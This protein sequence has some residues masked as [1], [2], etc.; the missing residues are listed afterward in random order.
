MGSSEAGFLSGHRRTLGN[1]LQPL[2]LYSSRRT[3]WRGSMK[4]GLHF[5]MPSIGS[6]LHV[7]IK[8]SICNL[9]GFLGDHPSP[10]KG[11]MKGRVE[12]LSL[13]HDLGLEGRLTVGN[14]LSHLSNSREPEEP[15]GGE[16]SCQR[17]PKPSV[18]CVHEQ[19]YSCVYMW[20]VCM[21][22]SGCV[23]MHVFVYSCVC[24]C[25]YMQVLEVCA[26]VL[27]YVHMCVFVCACM[28]LVVCTSGSIYMRVCVVVYTWM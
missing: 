17:T 18:W 21:H 8:K 7:E 2:T 3:V 25:V 13:Q 6:K 12:M 24:G 4:E 20:C 26:Y 1:P 22:V 16:T 19:M 28:C 5:L 11:K 14:Q 9:R 15:Q 27:F 10:R 23:C